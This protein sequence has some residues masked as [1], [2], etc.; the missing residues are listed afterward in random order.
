[1]AYK[2]L[3]RKY[4]P[5]NF[6]GVVGQVAIIKTLQNIVKESKISHAYLFSG[7]RG[8]GKTSVAKIFAKAINCLSPID[9]MPCGKCTICKQLKCDQT[10][11]I[12]EIDA[13]SNNGVDE[14]RDLKSKI[15]LAPTSCKYKVYIIDEVHMLSI[16]AFNA[17][18]KTL[19]EPPQHVIFILATT[20]IHKLPLT[21]ISR[22]QNYNFKKITEEQMKLRLSYIVECEKINIQ[23]EALNEIA[24]VSDGGM[25]DAI[26]LLEQLCSFTNNKIS[27]EDVELLG[28]SVPRNNI[29]RLINNLVDGN[30]EEIFKLN[31]FFYQSGKDFVKI[32][33][34]IVIFLRDALLYKR[35]EKYF[36]KNCNY[37]FN[38]F[39]NLFNKLNDIIIY[40]YI[41]E[42][43]KAI[44]DIKI[45]NH[46]KIIFEI[47]L[48]KLINSSAVTPGDDIS[49][50]T[51]NTNHLNSGANEISVL[52]TVESIKEVSKEVT[53]KTDETEKVKVDTERDNENQKN[54]FLPDIHIPLYKKVL[55][56]NTLAEANKKLMTQI[57]SKLNNLSTFLI[58]KDFKQAASILMDGKIVGIS[59]SNVIFTYQY[60]GVVDKADALLNEIETLINNVTAQR[61]KVINITDIN[62]QDIRPY[63]VKVVKEKG[64]IQI[65][66][67]IDY[68]NIKTNPKHKKSVKEIEDAI[69]MFGEDLIEIK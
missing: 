68:V 16:G 59:D 63:F 57:N 66:P 69:N 4:R 22:C 44:V 32:A 61:F 36:K 12:I 28:S 42:L 25:R 41:G 19:E 47:T 3:Y 64:K 55:I 26:G 56:N 67:E 38:E 39:I 45:S 6:N 5:D 54:D 33:E 37:N 34:D 14:I 65:L 29:A 11:D 50:S 51:N 10:N 35:A 60:D 27:L 2:A 49:V 8:T 53:V 15:N 40:K 1:M 24:R 21:I 20:E 30:A 52:K 18:L 58:N 13:A 46:P 43:N 7:P 31:D 17:L 62:W 9:G 23:G 48:L